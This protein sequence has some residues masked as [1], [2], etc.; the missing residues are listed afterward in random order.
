MRKLV[1][2]SASVLMLALLAGVFAVPSAL[3]QPSDKEITRLDR[4]IDGLIRSIDDIVW[5]N[6]IIY[7]LQD[8]YKNRLLTSLQA[9]DS[10]DIERL[11]QIG[12]VVAPG[13]LPNFSSTAITT[14]SGRGSRG[15]DL[16]K[17]SICQR[18]PEYDCEYD[19][20]NDE[21]QRAFT[22]ASSIVQNRASRPKDFFL[23]ASRDRTNPRLIALLG[24]D[25]QSGSASLM[26]F[27]RVGSQLYDYLT[28]NNA[29]STMYSELKDAIR[30][31]SPSLSNQMFL[32]RD[33][34]KVA[35]VERTK[36]IATYIDETENPWVIQSISMGRPIREAWTPPPVEDTSAAGDDAGAIDF[37][38]LL[39]GG[40]DIFGD[41]GTKSLVEGAAVPGAVEHPHEI[42]IGTDVIAGYY[43]YE[44]NTEKQVKETKW[45]LE[46][47][48]NFDEL[49]YPSIWGGRMTLNAILRNIK[50]GAV[51]PQIRFGGNTIA[52]SGLFDK[53][54]R[55]LGGYGIAFG[56]DFAAPVLNN[57]GL[58]N[59]HASYTFGEAGTDAVAKTVYE[60]QPG[61]S[62]L[63]DPTVTG[64]R[65][66]LIRYAFQGFY[67]F[68]FYADNESQHLFRMKL[69]GTVY[70]VDE[71]ER[72]QVLGRGSDIQTDTVP[73]LEKVSSETIGGIAGRIEYMKGGTDIPYGIGLQYFDAAI[74][75]N[76][77]IQFII[78]RSL[79]LK[80]EGRF[81]S[82]VFRDAKPWEEESLIIPSLEVKYHFGTP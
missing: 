68:G 78:S 12:E 38:A 26:S 21:L 60:V 36:A 61:D 22:I 72:R 37:S 46:L 32:L 7:R 11:E 63:G 67:S 29:D 47:L 58:F 70:G 77:W 66:Y 8:D 18:Y 45:G 55:I 76:I 40:T 17:A 34:S 57:S 24:V 27:R 31:G 64:E 71:F 30:V 1:S 74:Q 56:G 28:S 16:F 35:I 9:E 53:P 82:S 13:P 44:M 3:A 33:L 81:F 25:F 59:F 80:L 2:S 19:F 5:S 23:V 51:L 48:N 4:E 79:D 20:D 73:G 10:A 42:V 54:Q 43:S 14:A 65:G 52:E 6:I 50:L 75:S 69:G 15:F 49:N 39:G 62:G 41:E